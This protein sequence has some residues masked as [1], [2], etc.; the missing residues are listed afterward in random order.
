MGYTTVRISDKAHQTLKRLAGRAGRPMQSLLE[1][2]VEELRRQSFLEQVNA[3]CA[4][5][6]ADPDE[7]KSVEAERREWDATLADGLTVSE[8]RSTYR[9]TRRR[10]G[11][12]R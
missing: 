5:L 11:A 7:W 10:K 4:R 2:A 8:A 3:A 9:P 12:A 1:E 6:R